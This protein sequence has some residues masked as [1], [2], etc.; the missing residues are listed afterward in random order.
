MTTTGS[1]WQFVPSSLDNF[2]QIEN[3]RNGDSFSRGRYRV[4][5]KLGFG[6]FSTVWLGQD[7]QI[8]TAEASNTY[9]ELRILQYLKESE[10]YH[11][12]CDYI[13]S[14]VD[15]FTIE[16]PNGFHT[17]LVSP[18]AGPSLAQITYTP[19]QPA[20]SRRLRGAL[21]RNSRSRGV[22]HGDLNSSNVLIQLAHVDSWTEQDVYERLR[23]PVTAKVRAWSGELN[24]KPT[25]SYFAPEVVF[26]GKASVWSDNWAL[27]CT[28]FEIRAGF[29]LFESFFDDPDD[30]I[31]QMVQTLGKL[32]EPWWSSWERGHNY[33]D[34]SG[35]PKI[36]IGLTIVPCLKTIR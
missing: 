35:K 31:W 29:Q 15:H 23:F 13:L 25:V 6:G 7:E 3:Y 9:D 8:I 32:P 11:P 19:S 28:I 10:I 24:D 2:E 21:S 1:S 4:L 22:A 36:F 27:G 33:F 34:E 12:A 20:G 5:H 26:E 18:F 16:G 30:V 17:C 14:V